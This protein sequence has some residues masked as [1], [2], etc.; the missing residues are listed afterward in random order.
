[1]ERAGATGGDEDRAGAGAGNTIVLKTAEAAPLAVLLLSRL[2]AGPAAAR[3]SNVL[4]GYGDEA[5]EALT[6]HPDIDKISFTGS[7]AVGSRVLTAAAERIVPVSL[8][9]GG[10]NPQIVFPT[11]MKT[12]WPTA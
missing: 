7:T 6:H 1:V 3:R 8:E 9:L 11:P 10:K 4:T 2:A 12:G 5:G